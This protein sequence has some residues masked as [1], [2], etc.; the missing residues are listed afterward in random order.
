MKGRTL[1]LAILALVACWY[2]AIYFLATVGIRLQHSDFYPLWNGARA[3]LSGENPYGPEV[4]VQNQIAAYGTTADAIGEKNEQRF[5]Y[6]VYATFPILPLALLSFRTANLLAF[7]LIAALVVLSVGWIRGSGTELP[8]YTSFSPSR[9]IRW[10]LACR[11]GSRPCCSSV[12]PS[13][14]SHC[15][16]RDIC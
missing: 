5:A 1:I 8:A 15:F 9:A 14:A 7:C 6:P 16:S 13:P 4:T 11:S 3:V 10:S 12:S 2:F